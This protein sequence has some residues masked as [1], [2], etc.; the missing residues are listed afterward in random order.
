VFVLD[1][2]SKFA[3]LPQMKL[4][5]IAVGGPESEA[6]EALAG[7][8]LICDSFLSPSSAV[9]HALP[10][11]LSASAEPRATIRRRV[12]Q[13]YGVLSRCLSG[14]A[15]T[16]LTYEGGWY[17]VVRLPAVKTEIAW[18][19]GLLDECDVLVQPGFLYDFESEPFVVVSLLTDDVPFAEGIR[20][21]V[22]Y[23]VRSV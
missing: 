22:D 21:L 7:L 11:L 15:L 4:A 8:E 10:S 19:L 9:Q 17:G 1:G 6:V 2:L 18:V 3:A 13:N 16:P 23:V 5:W 20:R 14:T 12:V